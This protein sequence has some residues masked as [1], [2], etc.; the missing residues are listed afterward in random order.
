MAE[1]TVDNMISSAIIIN[2]REAF[3]SDASKAIEKAAGNGE[4]WQGEQ[5]AG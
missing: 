2:E 1:E 3:K 4:G 5:K